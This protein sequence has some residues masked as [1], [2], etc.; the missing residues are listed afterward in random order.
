MTLSL[1]INDS[2]IALGDYSPDLKS[3]IRN[4]SGKFW[5]LRHIAQT[6][7]L[8]RSLRRYW[9]IVDIVDHQV[10]APWDA[11][12]DWF[13]E[14][15]DIWVRRIPHE[16]RRHL[17]SNNTFHVR[18][19]S[20]GDFKWLV[21]VIPT[22][23]IHNATQ[24]KIEAAIDA[25]RSHAHEK[26]TDI[27]RYAQWEWVYWNKDDIHIWVVPSFNIPILTVTEDPNNPN[28]LFIDTQYPTLSWERNMS[29]QTYTHNESAWMFHPQRWRSRY[30]ELYHWFN[31]YRAIQ[32]LKREVFDQ[33][34]TYQFELWWIQET[35][36]FLLLQVK[37]FAKKN[38]IQTDQAIEIVNRAL[39]L[40]WARITQSNVSRI[41]T[42]LWE[43][44]TLKAPI[45]D[46]QFRWGIWG[47][48]KDQD[49]PDGFVMRPIRNSDDL[50]PSDY[51]PRTRWFLH[52]DAW[53]GTLAHYSF[54]FAQTAARNWWVFMAGYHSAAD[55]QIPSATALEMTVKDG[56][57]QLLW[58]AWASYLGETIH[59]S[60]LI[61]PQDA[62]PDRTSDSRKKYFTQKA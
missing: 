62:W 27:E 61:I 5:A 60:D 11:P 7:W 47:K 4:G 21:D 41:I 18:W 46:G 42:W 54:R 16:F 8:A 12:S 32:I 35:G 31:L 14:S 45:V 43:W 38:P 39:H 24:D 3:S 9:M 20:P 49:F 59:M 2:W 48:V 55:N 40:P 34:M 6:P 17:M 53:G 33:N 30:D 23:V 37:E 51:D 58:N 50:T 1:W 26:N 15:I 36:E 13:F 57:L 19:G 29:M 44:D 22:Q 10:L 56:V 52:V 25:I 28:T